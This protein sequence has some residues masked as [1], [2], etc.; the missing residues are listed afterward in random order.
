MEMN[1]IDHSDSDSGESWTIL[2]PT[3]EYTEGTLQLPQ[4]TNE[5]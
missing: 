5:R 3:P 1:I 2:E 4:D